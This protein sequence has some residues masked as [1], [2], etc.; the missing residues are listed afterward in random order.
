[1]RENEQIVGVRGVVDG[2]ER[3]IQGR[4]VLGCDGFNSMVARKAGLYAHES[5]H[6]VVA[7]RRY[8]E[9]VAGLGE[10]NRVAFCR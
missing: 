1:M 4:V 10:S 2:R 8:Y 7:I 9:N 6:W 5:V 3:E